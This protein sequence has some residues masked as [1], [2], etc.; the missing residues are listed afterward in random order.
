MPPPSSLRPSNHTRP[1]SPLL[2]P[3]AHLTTPDQ[4]PSLLH[5]S[6]P[7][8]TPCPGRAANNTHPHLLRSPDRP[9]TLHC[10]STYAHIQHPAP[11]RPATK[12]HTCC[13]QPHWVPARLKSATRSCAPFTLKW[14]L[15]G[16]NSA[17][18][19]RASSPW[20]ETTTN[21][22][23]PVA[24]AGVA[25]ARGAMR[26]LYVAL[27][28][29]PD[30]SGTAASG[31]PARSSAA[32]PTALPHGEDSARVKRGVGSARGVPASVAPAATVRLAG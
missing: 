20:P 17:Q 1:A 24:P 27:Y 31:A 13:A 7:P 14:W 30:Q 22:Q 32:Q 11:P 2:H 16:Q 18:L 28:G 4:L 3:S 25:T 19:A 8:T 15:V 26:L 9:P 10:A 29:P 12:P 5:P 21:R 6:A 23:P